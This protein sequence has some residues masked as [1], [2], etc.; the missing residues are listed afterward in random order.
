MKLSK[1]QVIRKFKKLDNSFKYS[2]LS[3]FYY[4]FLPTFWIK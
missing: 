2:V 3:N 1:S 4:D